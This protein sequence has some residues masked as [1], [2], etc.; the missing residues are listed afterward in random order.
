MKSLC[1]TQWAFRTLSNSNKTILLHRQRLFG[2]Y[3]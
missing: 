1:N 2:V 3:D